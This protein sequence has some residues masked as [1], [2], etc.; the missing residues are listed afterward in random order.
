MSAFLTAFPGVVRAVV[1]DVGLVLDATEES[2]RVVKSRAL[3]DT[4]AV[5]SVIDKSLVE[6]LGLVPFDTGRAYTAQGF[7]DSSI[8][9]LDVMLPN[10]I[11]VKGLRVGDG[12]FQGFDMLLGM[13]V[14]S[15]GD[16]HLTNDG[17]TVFKFVIPPEESP[18][19][20]DLKTSLQ[21]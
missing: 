15:L 5:T 8:Y 14:I 21:S 17:N 11:I 2:M 3:W 6:K 20:R 7:Y 19:N 9:L 1:T 16:F 18:S 4:G 12:D 13:D 10:N